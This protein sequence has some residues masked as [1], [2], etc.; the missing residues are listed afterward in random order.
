MQEEAI[1]VVEKKNTKATP[2][3][4]KAMPTNE[5]PLKTSPTTWA[6]TCAITTQASAPKVRTYVKKTKSSEVL[7]DIL[8]PSRVIKR[9]RFI[10]HKEFDDEEIEFDDLT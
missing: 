8:G 9:L 7:V 10:L 5:E 1:E 6:H 4:Q 2:K 3:R